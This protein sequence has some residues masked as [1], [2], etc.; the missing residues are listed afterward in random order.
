M[1]TPGSGA[2]T[3]QMTLQRGQVCLSLPNGLIIALANFSYGQSIQTAVPPFMRVHTNPNFGQL[4]IPDHQYAKSSSLK[5][6]R[7]VKPHPNRAND[8]H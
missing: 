5:C 8:D 2:F 3:V 7:Q 1:R 6:K 4:Y